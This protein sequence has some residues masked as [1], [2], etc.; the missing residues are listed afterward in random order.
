MSD[1]VADGGVASAPPTMVLRMT[2]IMVLKMS[3]TIN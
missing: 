1:Y 2:R 3:H